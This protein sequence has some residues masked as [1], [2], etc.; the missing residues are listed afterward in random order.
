MKG[1]AYKHKRPKAKKWENSRDTDQIC[2]TKS[3]HVTVMI[4]CVQMQCMK[5]H[6]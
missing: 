3:L 6:N 1:L 5:Q 4:W 2:E